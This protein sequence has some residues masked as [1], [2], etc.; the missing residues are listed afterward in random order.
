MLAITIQ[1][2]TPSPK[3]ILH[4]PSPNTLHLQQHAISKTTTSL[5]LTPHSILPIDILSKNIHQNKCWLCEF[6]RTTQTQKE[7]QLTSRGTVVI[8]CFEENS[9]AGVKDKVKPCNGLPKYSQNHSHVCDCGDTHTNQ[10]R[11]EQTDVA[12]N[13]AMQ[14][15]MPDRTSLGNEKSARTHF[16]S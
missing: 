2:L 11:G 4:N 8:V 15:C 16:Q 3:I 10:P 6:Q 7:T 1:N 9:A 14:L 5:K 12:C 13:Q